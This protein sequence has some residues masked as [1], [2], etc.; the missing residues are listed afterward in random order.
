MVLFICT[1]WSWKLIPL[2]CL[3]C[4]I[5]PAWY[6]LRQSQLIVKNI[7]SSEL[8][9]FFM[10]ILCNH[11]PPPISAKTNKLCYIKATRMLCTSV[12]TPILY[13]NEQ[14]KSF[15]FC[16]CR[17]LQALLCVK[18][19]VLLMTSQTCIKQTC[20]ICHIFRNYF[21]KDLFFYFTVFNE[22][23]LITAVAIAGSYS[24]SEPKTTM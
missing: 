6:N 16:C 11:P 9:R 23:F 12:M 17:H 10:V 7:T 22:V 21:L 8:S 3:L 20:K 15:Y 1:N 2:W 4:R 13:S 18:V 19:R 5:I 24:V 14:N